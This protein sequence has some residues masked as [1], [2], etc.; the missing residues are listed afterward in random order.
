MVTEW[1]RDFGGLYPELRVANRYLTETHRL[2]ACP[3]ESRPQDMPAS[4]SSDATEQ[5]RRLSAFRK[6]YLK[7]V[8]EGGLDRIEAVLREAEEGARVFIPTPEDELEWRG[9]AST[10]LP[11]RHPQPSD[12][13]EKPSQPESDDE[14]DSDLEW[15]AGDSSAVREL[16]AQFRSSH[17]GANLNTTVTAAALGSDAYELELDLSIQTVVPASNAVPDSLRDNVRLL[18]GRYSSLMCGWLQAAVAG[19]Q[20]TSGTDRQQ[21]RNLVKHLTQIRE[22]CIKV[23]AK[24]PAP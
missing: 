18:R 17:D 13:L 24:F 23:V 12:A 14:G 3:A 7:A 21:C 22:R 15:E 8:D 9:S 5:G 4:Q 20:H 10:G 6:A 19:E 2:H 1:D 11:G 16:E